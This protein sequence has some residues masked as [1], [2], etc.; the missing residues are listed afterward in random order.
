MADDNFVVS[1]KDRILDV[2]KPLK[3]YRNLTKKGTWYSLIQDGKTVAHTNAICLRDCTFHVNEKAR[4]RVIAKRKKEFHAYILGYYAT[5]G[6]GTTAAKN[7]LS[8]HIKY[9]PYK[10]VGFTCS[11]LTQKP[12]IIKWALFV[13]CN[14]EGVRAAYT[15]K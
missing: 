8:V 15:S 1:Y 5:S 6:M 4:Q 2:T 9:N 13:I 10:N 11:N 7:N 12:F 14:H 3:L